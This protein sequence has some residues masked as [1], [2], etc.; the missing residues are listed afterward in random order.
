MRAPGLV[1]VLCAL[2]AAP[3]AAVAEGVRDPDAAI[4]LE[5][6]VGFVVGEQPVGTVVGT[7][8]GFHVDGGLRAGRIAALGEYWFTTLSEDASDHAPAHA[9]LQRLGAVAR[10][11]VGVLQT[12]DHFA[13]G[14]LWIEAGVG[15]ELVTWRDGGTLG[16]TDVA[17]GL[18]GQFRI[19]YGS[20]ERRKIGLYYAARFL[21][22]DR[23][24][25]KALPAMCGG[26]CDEPSR[27]IP[28]DIG[29]YFNLG[30]LFR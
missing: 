18:A 3:A 11:S 9:Y 24:G 29:I 1:A 10:Y 19:R 17:F 20:G 14:D 13:R 4:H 21:F 30:V 16:R 12:E 22:A 25:T 28:V 6:G 26:P 7:A 23:P 8:V 5:G 27:A 2:C 15:R